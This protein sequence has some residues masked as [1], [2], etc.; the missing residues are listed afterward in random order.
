MGFIT[1]GRRDQWCWRNYPGAPVGEVDAAEGRR[2]EGGTASL[3]GG[4]KRGRGWDRTHGDS[5]PLP[6]STSLCLFSTAPVAPSP[7]PQV[8]HS[9]G[10]LC[11]SCC[12]PHPLTS[13]LPKLVKPKCGPHTSSFGPPRGLDRQAGSHHHPFALPNQLLNWVSVERDP[14]IQESGAFP[15][16]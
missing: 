16:A 7:P 1:L 13:C 10:P 5:P 6:S 3:E 4:G 14:E 11:S 15:K 12:L 8:W 2:W 9:P